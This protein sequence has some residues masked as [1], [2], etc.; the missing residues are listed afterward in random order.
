MGPM[1]LPTT[2]MASLT[3]M[4]IG[5]LPIIFMTGTMESCFC[6]A[7][8]LSEVC[9]LLNMLVRIVG[10]GHANA[11]IPP[12]APEASDGRNASSIPWSRLHPPG[13]A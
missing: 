7:V 5:S 1:G 11:I 8:W 10:I 12:A 13:S 6:K 2:F 9:Q 3:S 4:G